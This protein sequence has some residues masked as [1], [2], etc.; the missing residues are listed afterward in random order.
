MKKK[1]II[2]VAVLF[3]LNLV[4]TLGGNAF[5]CAQFDGLIKETDD[6]LIHDSLVKTI[7]TEK[8]L[9]EPELT[10]EFI[11]NKIHMYINGYALG[12]PFVAAHYGVFD[13]N[14]R[15]ICE[16]DDTIYLIESK[17]PDSETEH[18]VYLCKVINNSEVYD[19]M[20]S[21]LDYSNDEVPTV[22]SI[23]RKGME[24][25][26]TEMIFSH[27]MNGEEKEEKFRYNGEIEDGFETV[28]ASDNIKLFSPVGNR[29]EY[30]GYEAVFYDACTALFA[31]NNEEYK[32][33]T[34]GIT[35]KEESTEEKHF[36]RL[37]LFGG[38]S[39]K[40]ITQTITDK[41]GKN[42]HIVS[43]YSFNLRDFFLSYVLMLYAFTILAAGF[44]LILCSVSDHKKNN[45]R[46]KSKEE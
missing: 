30:V 45:K 8:T 12:T 39:T 18:R 41:G 14:G 33:F 29:P 27:T 44:I 11:S 36:N 1:I 2:T 24:C 16:T 3:V 37:F 40:H 23:A 26:V 34:D 6:Y 46:K 9:T 43:V 31:R 4:L 25:Y 38:D 22:L 19:F 17:Y 21:C 42:Y 15:L 28:T 10:D 32:A 35:F 5:A 7:N 20:Q 13:D